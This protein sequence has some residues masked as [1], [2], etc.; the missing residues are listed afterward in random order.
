[1]RKIQFYWT[2]EWLDITFFRRGYS[3][4]HSPKNC[5]RPNHTRFMDFFLD[6]SW[7]LKI[8]SK[9][10]VKGVILDLGDF[11]GLLRFFWDF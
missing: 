6:F 8:R 11:L 3:T 7:I 10:D 9:N 4:L 2:K 1:M 5:L